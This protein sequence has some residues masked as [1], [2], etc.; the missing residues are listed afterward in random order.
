MEKLGPKLGPINLVRVPLIGWCTYE[1]SFDSSLPSRPALLKV[2]TSRCIFSSNIPWPSVSISFQWTRWRP[3]TS[4]AHCS[5]I[6]QWTLH[7]A[8][9]PCFPWVISISCHFLWLAS[10]PDPSFCDKTD[11]DSSNTSI[12][13]P[14][15]LWMKNWSPL[16]ELISVRMT[17]RVLMKKKF[18]DTTKLWR[19]LKRSCWT[20]VRQRVFSFKHQVWMDLSFGATWAE[21]KLIGF[22]WKGRQNLAGSLALAC[23][24]LLMER[25]QCEREDS[26]QS[27]RHPWTREGTWRRRRSKKEVFKWD[28]R[29][30]S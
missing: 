5:S 8:L 11:N 9:G 22:N 30:W 13:D 28:Q 4:R 2:L 1:K 24:C 21:E 6:P 16:S 14:K 19:D 10:L 26:S 17:G 29:R 18:K 23:A 27:S 25:S 20:V 3:F 7:G 12:L 15:G